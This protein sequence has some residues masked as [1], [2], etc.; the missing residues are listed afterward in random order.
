MTVSR[1]YS[2]TVVSFRFGYIYSLYGFLSYSLFPESISTV[3][4]LQE[5]IKNIAYIYIYIYFCC[6]TQRC[7]ITIRRFAWKLLS[8]RTSR[9]FPI[10]RTHSFSIYLK[11]YAEQRKCEG[12]NNSRHR[13]F[14][15]AVFNTL[16]VA[17]GG[18]LSRR[19]VL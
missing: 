11:N 13:Y 1:D 9:Q 4:L 5:Y 6:V 12:G 7:G 10:H 18:R 15:S 16:R 19:L 2:Y 8:Q 14:P 3:I 17:T